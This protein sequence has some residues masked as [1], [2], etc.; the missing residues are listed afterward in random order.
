MASDAGD[1]D[2][3]FSPRVGPQPMTLAVKPG[4]E[5]LWTLVGMDLDG[6]T[7]DTMTL[8]FDPNSLMVTDVSFGQAMAIDIR[9]PPAV[10]ISRESGTIKITSSD[11]KALRFNSGG[12]ILSMRVRGGSPGE[13]FLVVD[14]PSFRNQRGEAVASTV[15]G[16][17]LRVQ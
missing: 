13:S 6:L 7:T 8:R 17:R 11:G 3:R 10:V 1:S 14:Q 4:E 16:G 9:T 5:H 15:T 12:D 2:M